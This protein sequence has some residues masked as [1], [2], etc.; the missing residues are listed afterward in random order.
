MPFAAIVTEIMDDDLKKLY[1]G[2]SFLLEAWDKG[3]LKFQRGFKKNIRV[4][5]SAR[6]DN[7]IIYVP[8][9]ADE[10]EQG[11]RQFIYLVSLG[12]WLNDVN[13][14]KI[15]DWTGL[16][17]NEEELKGMNC[18]IDKKNVLYMSVEKAIFAVSMDTLVSRN[19]T[20]GG[21]QILS[22]GANTCKGSAQF[23]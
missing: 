5:N 18:M 21:G 16:C 11:G 2:N 13:E 7:T 4:F 10:D 14:R 12:E 3:R 23:G 17:S 15:E 9:P 8:D 20:S 22:V 1:G 19:A 6:Q